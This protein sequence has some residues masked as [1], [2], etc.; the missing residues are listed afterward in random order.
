MQNTLVRPNVAVIR[1]QGH[2][3]ASNAVEFQGQLTEAVS[4]PDQSIV[5]VDMAQVEF[6][7]SAGLMALVSA[8]RLAHS[9]GRRFSLS[10]VSAS[11]RMIF[12]LAQLDGVFE[13]F[14]SPAALEANI[15]V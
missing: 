5:L 3:N 4:S 9:L 1:P 12:E 6:L 14:E 8:H 10:S 13:I 2:I 11:I 7:D 15:G